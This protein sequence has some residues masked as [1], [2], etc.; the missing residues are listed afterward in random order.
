MYIVSRDGLLLFSPLNH[1]D[2]QIFFLDLGFDAATMQIHRI[3]SISKH[4][5]TFPQSSWRADEISL[6]T[7]RHAIKCPPL[8]QL[9][10]APR[11]TPKVL[12]SAFARIYQPL[13]S[14]CRRFGGAQ[15]LELAFEL[16]EQ[17]RTGRVPELCLGQ[18]DG[19][20]PRALG[21]PQDFVAGDPP[22][23]VSRPRIR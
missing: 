4:K 18:L 3:S 12:G 14:I 2:K 22:R 19:H 5:S 21:P 20:W 16:G 17:P 9:N 8:D 15:A 10:A 7:I 23:P 11:N 13:N 6:I 1:F